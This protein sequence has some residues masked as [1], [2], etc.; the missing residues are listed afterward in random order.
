M[1]SQDIGRR[2]MEM[3]RVLPAGMTTAQL[4]EQ[5]GMPVKKVTGHV[6]KLGACGYVEI[7]RWIKGTPAT[8]VWKACLVQPLPVGR[9]KSG[10]KPK[11]PIAAQDGMTDLEL[12]A[13]VPDVQGGFN[14]RLARL[15]PMAK[16]KE[17]AG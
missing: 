11:Q 2:I 1:K 17:P 7:G 3:L 14:E 13:L 12:A 16:A 4:A 15:G 10:P 5:L 6:S 9:R 8:R